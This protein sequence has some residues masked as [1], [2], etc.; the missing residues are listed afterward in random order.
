MEKIS[1]EPQTGA[2]DTCFSRGRTTPGGVLEVGGGRVFSV[3]T[4]T[5]WC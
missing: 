1:K 5:G 2:R 4:K 3:I